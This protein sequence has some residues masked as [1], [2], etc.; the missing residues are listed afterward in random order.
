MNDQEIDHHALTTPR[1][2]ERSVKALAGHLAGHHAAKANASQATA[3]SIFRWIAD[4]ITYG[5]NPASHPRQGG[6]PTPDQVLRHR[7]ALCGGFARLYQALGCAAG[8][9]VELVPGH[10]KGR[11]YTIGKALKGAGDHLWNA[12]RLDGKWHLLDV[13]WGAGV[14]RGEGFHQEFQPHYFLTPPALFAL[15]HLPDDPG[16]QLLEPPVSRKVFQELPIYKPPYFT[17]G[18]RA[19]VDYPGTLPVRDQFSIVLE[20]PSHVLAMA[21][22][23]SRGRPLPDTLTFAQHS[24]GRVTLMARFPRP[25]PYLLRIYGKDQRAG[26]PYQWALDYRLQ[27]QQGWGSLPAF[28]KTFADFASHQALLEEPLAGRLAAGS[29]Q[30]FRIHLPGAESV[31]LSFNGQWHPMDCQD[32]W[33]TTRI[34]IPRGEITLAATMPGMDA[35]PILLKFQSSS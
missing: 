15:D 23:W 5:D 22:L 17:L 13:T 18:L 20:R 9:E 24:P 26:E 21:E 27:A 6:D 4:R 35:M 10:V 1:T 14:V 11:G 31:G 19:P 33:F 7:R 16:W 28:P 30:R 3:R 32:G 29:Q 12:V 2:A 8:L 34:R 25:G